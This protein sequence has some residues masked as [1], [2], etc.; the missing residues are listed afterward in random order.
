MLQY[1]RR[2]DYLSGRIVPPAVDESLFDHPIVGYCNWSFSGAHH[3][4]E[5]EVE[6]ALLAY[7]KNY[8]P[9]YVRIFN[10]IPAEV[11]FDFIEKKH[12]QEANLL[13]IYQNTVADSGARINMGLIRTPEK[14]QAYGIKL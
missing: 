11:T 2:A 5:S 7:N 14:E 12:L 6:K 9:F 13:N 8:L 1:I 10:E 4:E 3:I